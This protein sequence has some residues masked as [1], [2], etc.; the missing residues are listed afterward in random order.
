MDKVQI[1]PD[2][3]VD[4]A[5]AP[6]TGD[7]VDKNGT[8]SV[9]LDSTVTKTSAD[10]TVPEKFR[11]QDGS[12]DSDALLKS[13]KELETRQSKTPEPK[14][15]K[16]PTITEKAISTDDMAKLND[17]FAKSGKLSDDTYKSLA[18]K[19]L[20][21][22]LVDNYI[23]GQTARANAYTNSLRE[24][25]G[26]KEALDSLIEWAGNNLSDSEI[27]TANKALTGGDS[28]SA[29]LV[30][31]GLRARYTKAN[32]KDPSL[33]NSAGGDKTPDVKPFAS[34]AELVEAMSDPRYKNGPKGD[35]AYRK[36]VEARIAAGLK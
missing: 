31:D 8:S 32:G 26:G 21:K 3:K 23:A 1:T 14:D 15:D 28:E 35:P 19:G 5:V 25:V 16:T 33:L 10:N 22:E 30:L 4:P 24:H 12:L 7:V 2:A 11:K 9:T 17:E 27:K 18:G 29:K 20:S 6:K 36:Q 13:Y 34:N